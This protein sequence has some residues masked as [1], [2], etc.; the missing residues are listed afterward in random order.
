MKPI[1]WIYLILNVVAVLGFFAYLISRAREA[2]KNPE[3]FKMKEREKSIYLAIKHIRKHKKFQSS[4]V[5]DILIIL[6]TFVFTLQMILDFGFYP[7]YLIL[8][9]SFLLLCFWPVTF[10]IQKDSFSFTHFIFF[11]Q[12]F[13]FKDLRRIKIRYRHSYRGN[14]SYVISVFD[15]QPHFAKDVFI[16]NQTM[17]HLCFIDAAFRSNPDIEMEI[18][19]SNHQ[20]MLEL[21]DLMLARKPL[22][23]FQDEQ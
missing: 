13:F 11:T 6:L 1:F 5:P 2:A 23:I 3:F 21:Q 22:G 12:R 16:W 20:P 7:V 4:V 17:L 9:T 8:Y 19:E 14:S 10:T 15:K 18:V